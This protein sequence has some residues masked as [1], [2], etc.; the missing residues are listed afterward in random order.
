M[1][2]PSDEVHDRKPAGARQWLGRIVLAFV[3]LCCLITIV[4]SYALLSSERMGTGMQRSVI[5]AMVAITS[6]L[7]LIW[8]TLFAPISSK[9]RHAV[10]GTTL[11]IILVLVAI[12]RLEEV[13]GGLRPRFAF[14]WTPTHDEQLAPAQKNSQAIDLTST[15]ADDFPQFLGPS[16][17]LSLPMVQLETDWKAHPPELI[18]KQPIGAGWSGFVAVNGFA[19]TQEQRGSQELVT[20]YRILTGELIWASGIPARHETTMGGI[21]PRATPCID[22]GRVYALGAVGVLRCLDGATGNEL[23]SHDLLAKASVSNDGQGVAWGRSGS[24]LVVDQLVVVPLGGP[25]DGKK[26]TLIAFDKVTGEEVWRGGDDQVSYASPSLVTLAGTRQILIVSENHVVGIRPDNGQ[27]LWSHD[28]PGGSTSA[29]NVSNAIGVSDRDVFVSKGYGQGAMLFEV[30]HD[31]D[32]W[33]TETIWD[34]KSVMKT[35]FTNVVVHEEHVYGLDDVILECIE[36]DS[37]RKKWKKGR[38]GYGQILR[39]GDTLLVLS[40]TG[41]LAAVELSPDEFREL[42]RMPVLEDKTWNNL[43]L[44]GPYLLVRNGVEAACYR[45]SLKQPDPGAPTV[46]ERG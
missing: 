12:L 19:I 1:S 6:F 42:A 2:S 26:S 14:R 15:S 9:V 39:A 36:L 44:Y 38:F 21:G 35:K 46:A 30:R 29:A 16:R 28:W 11:G 23:W 34:K 22:Q 40:E 10:A 41:E 17:D 13:D 18:W 45:L 4:G 3:I 37:G 25:R 20:C 32:A 33:S 31:G 43:C 24:P 5:A 27:V 8:F 7:A